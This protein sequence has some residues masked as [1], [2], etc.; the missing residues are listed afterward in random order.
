[1]RIGTGQSTGMGDILLLTSICKIV[2]GVAVEL[3]PESAKFMRFFRDQCSEVIF[4]NDPMDLP[5]IGNDHYARA[6]MRGLGMEN[7][8]HLPRVVISDTEKDTAKEMIMQYRS[9]VVFV[10]NCSKKWSSVR[11]LPKDFWMPILDNLAE[12]HDILQFGLSSNFTSFPQTIPMP[13]INL[14]ELIL[15]YYACGKYYG[16]ETGDKHLMLACGGEINVAR[17]NKYK[18]H[19]RWIYES[20]REKTLGVL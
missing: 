6:K 20:S 9:P 16:V 1:M 11:E 13:D 12:E 2:P 7:E 17:S 3:L 14:R 10:P 19:H 5:N 18:D 15:Y 8:C 4:K